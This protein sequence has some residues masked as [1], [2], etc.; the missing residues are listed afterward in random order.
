MQSPK[1]PL[2]T[3]DLQEVINPGRL[4]STWKHKVRDAMRTQLVFDPIENLDFHTQLDAMCSEIHAEVIS[5]AYIPRPAIRLLSEKSKGMCR[6]IVIPT[7]KDALILQSLSDALWVEL[8][9]KAPSK[10]AFYGPADHA[11]S[12]TIKGLTSEYGSLGAWLNFQEEIFGFTN[13]YRVIVVTDIAN[14]FDFISY[15]HLRNI[16][17]DL[18]IAREHALDLL[19]YTLSHMLWQPDYMPRVQVG[20]PQ[21][22]LDAP[23]LL[24]HC[25]LFEIDNLLV[26][27]KGIEFTRYMDDID[28]GTDTIA[29]AKA[30]LR[31]LDLSLQTRQIRLNSGKTKILTEVEAA[32]HFKIREN[33]FLD[34]FENRID[35]KQ[36]A[37]LSV[38][39][40]RRFL[41]YAIPWGL[42][43][44]CFATGNGEKI[45]KRCLN[46][47][48]RL[49]SFIQPKD[50]ATILLNW[51]TS[52]DTAL[53]WISHWS[54]P[55]F[56]LPAIAAVL[57]SG[58]ITDEST[59]VQIANA[60]V[61]S[62]IQ[63]TAETTG[64]LANIYAQIDHRKPWGFYSK[65]WLYSKYRSAKDIMDLIEASSLW[66]TQEVLARLVAGMF[67]RINGT[68]FQTKFENIIRRAS[69]RGAQEVLDFHHKLSN[70]TQGFTSVRKFL[71]APNPSLPN[72]LT[73][74]KFLMLLSSLRNQ[75]IPPVAISRLRN[76]HALALTD[77]FY[78]N[79]VVH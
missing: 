56:Y 52:R 60:I 7:V 79:I 19:I 48:R 28:I 13:K 24:A 50:I 11:F 46:Y 15:D 42:R 64:T 14:F 32:K 57:S 33:R 69:S 2:K 41:T 55:D 5:G 78:A 58:E 1:F 72:R 59:E 67:P 31:D 39:S 8:S 61:S 37:N 63:M 71:M 3:K 35:T 77:E 53:R 68:A 23:R 45:L 10:R 27:A 44:G 4:K 49:T 12:N 29:R 17:A 75:S 38:E 65:L 43:V 34:A 20:L 40:E 70:T 51:P 22:N 21:M 47:S 30:I 25:F 76:Q 74:A 36:R 9:K 62:R 16:L 18:S 54:Y 73:H 6:Q 26:R 66:V